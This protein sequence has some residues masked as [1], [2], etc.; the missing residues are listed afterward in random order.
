MSNTYCF[1]IMRIG[2]TP[3]GSRNF[4]KEKYMICVKCLVVV[5]LVSLHHDY[6]NIACICF[7]KETENSKSQGTLI[8]QPPKLASLR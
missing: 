8:N 3:K 6:K 1:S 5:Q 4:G 7:F 2:G